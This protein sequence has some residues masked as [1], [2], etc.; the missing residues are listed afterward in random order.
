M[1]RLFINL[2]IKAYLRKIWRT[3]FMQNSVSTEKKTN[4]PFDFQVSKFYSYTGPNYYLP[5]PATVFNLYLSPKGPGVDFFRDKVLAKFPELEEDYP[6][7]MARLFARVLM[8]AMKMDLDL[9]IHR[10]EVLRDGDEW[11]IAVEQLDSK[12]TE[13]VILFVSDWFIAMS[14]E[15]TAF[16]FDGGFAHL[17]EEFDQTLYGGPTIYSLVEG[18][19]KRGVN[20]DYLY[21]EN[22]FQWGYGKKQIRG[23]STIF[24]TDGIKDTEFTTYKDMVGDFLEMCG[25]PTPSG[26]NCFTE[27]EIVTEA[28][29]IG[30]PVVV[31]PVAGHKGQGVTTGIES[32]E[33]VKKAFNGI[34]RAAKD[35]GVAFEGALVQQQ[36]YGFDHRIL[37]I[38]GKYAACLKRIPAFVTGNGKNTIEELIAIENDREVRLDNARSPLAKI[39]IDNDLKDFLALQN[40]SLN[41]VPGDGQEVVLR[42]VANISAGGV[43]VNVTDDIHPKNVNMVENI[44]KFFHVTAMGIDV[45]AGDISKPWTEGNFGIIEINA[46]P[47]VFMHLAPA[48]GGMVDVPGKIWNYHFGE[49]PGFSRIP[50]VAGND[51]SDELIT[52]VYEELKQYKHDLEFGS[53]NK[54]GIYFNNIFFN[55][56]KYHDTNCSIV[57]RNPKLDFAM[58]NHYRDDIHD[59]GLWHTGLDVAILKHANYAEYTLERDLLPGGLLIEIVEKEVEQEVAVPEEAVNNKTVEATDDPE[60]VMEV[61]SELKREISGLKRELNRLKKDDE[62][63][64][65]ETTGTTPKETITQMI[66]LKDKEEISRTNINPGDDI[67]ALIFEVLKPYLKDLLFKYDYYVANSKVP[68]NLDKNNKYLQEKGLV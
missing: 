32:V 68:Q 49:I 48:E 41:S 63:D 50:I 24:H 61:V 2:I 39:N 18:A 31:K 57:L 34:L 33:E 45:L 8:Q 36:I 35:A 9:F 28:E 17:Q 62:D 23:R 21:E 59:Y 37:T 3:F 66:V 16:D 11:T 54:D 67:D 60:E 40:L 1:I 30:F 47:G 65:T 51:L 5:C 14:K 25:F 27:E 29:T 6:N 64:D 22:Q 43:S 46:G 7:R 52:K 20:V 13:E 19:V 56:H 58:F 4:E 44:A 55:N 26:K 38:G 10:Y 42:R 53:L 15:D 12:L